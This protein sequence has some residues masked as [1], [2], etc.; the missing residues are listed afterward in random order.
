MTRYLTGVSEYY[1][2]SWKDKMSSKEKYKE[3]SQLLLERD[4]D[5]RKMRLHSLFEYMYEKDA[6]DIA[7]WESYSPSV[8]RKARAMT[9]PPLQNIYEDTLLYPSKWVSPSLTRKDRRE[10]L[11]QQADKEDIK[12]KHISDNNNINNNNINALKTTESFSCK[13][14]SPQEKR[15]QFAKHILGSLPE[16]TIT[17]SFDD[18]TKETTA[19]VRLQSSAHRPRSWSH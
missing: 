17:R 9:V 8:V 18:E 3:M 1:G 7:Q 12:S 2:C 11:K 14:Y 10:R 15:R 5:C 19:T 16:D 13:C 4:N 6:T